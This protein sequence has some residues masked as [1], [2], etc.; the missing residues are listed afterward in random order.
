MKVPKLGETESQ[1]APLA[2]IK[3]FTPDAGWTW[4][5]T[6]YDGQDTLFGLVVGL[7]TEL[8]YFSLAELRQAR[9]PWGLPI[10]R[11]LWFTPALLSQ[12]PEYRARWG[13]NGPYR[14]GDLHR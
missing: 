13:N 5:I 12:L 1:S 14:R 4:F 6:E 7:E 2:V 9:G 11:D 3:L 8:G 10:E